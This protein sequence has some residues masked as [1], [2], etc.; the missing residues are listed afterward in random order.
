MCTVIQS[1]GM[2]R[3]P[4][5]RRS[6]TRR[7]EYQCDYFLFAEGAGKAPWTVSM[8]SRIIGCGW[9]E[10][11]AARKDIRVLYNLRFLDGVTKG[12][13]PPPKTFRI[14]SM[15]KAA[16]ERR[17]VYVRMCKAYFKSSERGFLIQSP[18]LN[19]YPIVLVVLRRDRSH[20]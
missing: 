2:L 19:S 3:A 11:T 14:K 18:C 15:Q 10:V 20:S 9:S 17:V 16:M 12:E 5:L 8:R 4:G 1:L 7:T 13:G 6:W